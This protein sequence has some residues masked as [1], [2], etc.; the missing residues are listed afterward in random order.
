MLKIVSGNSIILGL[1]RMNV[2][3]L[4]EGKP[5]QFNGATIGFPGKL[6]YIVFGETELAIA[7]S[8]DIDVAASDKPGH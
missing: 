5:I 1:S 7:E 6:F 3:K 2:E 8:L 4:M